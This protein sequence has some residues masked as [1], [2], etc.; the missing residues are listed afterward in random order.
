MYLLALFDH[1]NASLLNKIINLLKK[2]SSVCCS[3][4]VHVVKTLQFA[5]HK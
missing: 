2:K 4:T 5:F 1:F 3:E